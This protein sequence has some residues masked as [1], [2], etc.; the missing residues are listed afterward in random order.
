MEIPE[1][2]IRLAVGIEN[3]EDLIEDIQQALE[4]SGV[5]SA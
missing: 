5:K 2:L 4:V 1:G 3:V